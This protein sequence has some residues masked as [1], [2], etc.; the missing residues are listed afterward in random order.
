MMKKER[1]T[2]RLSVPKFSR[3]ATKWIPTG[4]MKIFES[5]HYSYSKLNPYTFFLFL[6][7]VTDL[8]STYFF[9]MEGPEVSNTECSLVRESNML[10]LCLNFQSLFITKVQEKVLLPTSRHVAIRQLFISFT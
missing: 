3:R 9:K 6:A 5:E 8:K 7:K 10:A 1:E 2:S 4:E